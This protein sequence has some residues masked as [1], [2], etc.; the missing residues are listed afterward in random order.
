M[1]RN[2][3]LILAFSL[4]LQMAIPGQAGSVTVPQGTSV[5]V[6][7]TDTVSSATHKKGD[8]IALAVVSDVQVGGK[9][10]IATGAPVKGTVESASKRFIAGIGGQIEISVNE[11]KAVDGTAVPLKFSKETH[12]G[13]T[14]VAAVVAVICCCC[15]W[16]IPG[17]D[18]SIEKGTLFDAVTLSS[19]EVH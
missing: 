10:V 5:I 7:L 19:V 11:V 15:A 13:S 17:K 18:V 12:N 3:G 2:L 8:A 6:K 16:L 14:L 4:I 1:K 9:N